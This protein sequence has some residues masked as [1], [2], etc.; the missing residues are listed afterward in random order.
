MGSKE[1]KVER[2]EGS[3]SNVKER[4]IFTTELLP[5]YFP[6]TRSLRGQ[7]GLYQI[8]N[9][10]FLHVLGVFA[11]VVHQCIRIG[12]MKYISFEVLEMNME[13]VRIAI[14]GTLKQLSMLGTGHHLRIWRLLR[15]TNLKDIGLH[16]VLIL[17]VLIYTFCFVCSPLIRYTFLELVH[18]CVFFITKVLQLLTLVIGYVFGEII[19]EIDEY[20]KKHIILYQLYNRKS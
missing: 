7:K 19:V 11:T 16:L 15:I 5:R 2:E 20:I 13:N 14:K 4:F 9:D 3:S 18:F 12:P 8:V 10:L 17:V 1:E 6:K